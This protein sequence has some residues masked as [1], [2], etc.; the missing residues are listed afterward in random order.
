MRRPEALWALLVVLGL[1]FT[2]VEA[3]S[4]SEGQH[5]FEFLRLPASPS[6]LSLGASEVA[7]AKGP[8]SLG[9]NPAGLI[10]DGLAQF[11]FAHLLLPERAAWEHG[12]ASVRLGPASGTFG[13]AVATLRTGSLEALDASGN[14][15][16]T[17]EPSAT[18]LRGGY[19]FVPARGLKLGLVAEL[20]QE[21][22]GMGEQAKGFGLGFGLQ[23]HLGYTA[24]GASLLHAGAPLEVD[25][26][27]FPLPT[28]LSV[29]LRHQVFSGFICA[30]AVQIVVGEGPKFATGFTWVPSPAI[31]LSLGAQPLGTPRPASSLC[32]GVQIGFRALTVS[33]ATAPAH[34][35]GAIHQFGL[36]LRP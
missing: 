27:A 5:A 1:G 12:S 26:E 28:T 15:L 35:M 24:L 22:D 23:G 30:A 34:E 19:A 17:F 8:S 9:C 16:G 4:S 25:Q 7:D 6:A 11:E 10:S 36:G 18:V 20:V 29:G 31:R 14:S 3:R 2:A 13:V 21:S 32:A 33:Y